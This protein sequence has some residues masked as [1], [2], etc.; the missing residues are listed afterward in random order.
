M[1]MSVQTPG[2]SE[3]KAGLVCCT[4]WDFRVRHYLATKQQQAS[5]AQSAEKGSKALKQ[6]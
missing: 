6:Y 5:G 4:P 2:D 3:A 1:D